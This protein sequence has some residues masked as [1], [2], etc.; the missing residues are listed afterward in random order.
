I[1]SDF[2]ASDSLVEITGFGVAALG[3]LSLLTLP[4]ARELLTGGRGRGAGTHDDA[5]SE[6]EDTTP[7]FATPLTRIA[8]NV[9]FPFA[10]LISIAHL[11]YSGDAPGDGFTAGVVGGLAIA[12]LYVVFGY[13]EARQRLSWLRP[14]TLIG[15]GLL[16]AFVNATLP[17]LFGR[18]FFALT[19]FAGINEP[20]ELHFASTLVFEIAIYLTVLG[21]VSVIMEAI[22]HPKEVESL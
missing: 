22:A 19:E 16:I 8:A 6:T 9:V 4:E 21:G 2:R 18:E 15:L 5:L 7:R 10:L 1:V 14:G 17:L 20:A 3:V 12:M 13:Y 11:L